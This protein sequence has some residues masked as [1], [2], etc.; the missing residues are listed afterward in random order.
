ML[1]SP[2][3]LLFAWISYSSQV[4]TKLYMY[5]DKNHYWWIP[6]SKL[7]SYIN[8]IER[9]NAT[10]LFS[11]A[12]YYHGCFSYQ[13]N[14][15][16]SNSHSIQIHYILARITSEIW[17]IRQETWFERSAQFSIFFYKYVH[18]HNHLRHAHFCRLMQCK[19]IVMQILCI[20][21]IEK[22]TVPTFKL[23]KK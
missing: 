17:R 7:C 18:S 12:K 21:K 13:I 2:F 6:N 5:E 15:S 14:I 22:I 19:Q 20:S 9:R 11:R 23:V 10:V 16:V 3:L 1:W 8:C 4:I